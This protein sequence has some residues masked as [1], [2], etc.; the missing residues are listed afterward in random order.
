[1]GFLSDLLKPLRGPASRDDDPDYSAN[2]ERIEKVLQTLPP[3]RARLLAAFALLLGRV[4]HSDDVISEGERTR[5]LKILR[6][7]LKLAE[8]QAAAVAAI[9]LDRAACF[10]SDDHLVLRRVRELATATERLDLIRALFHLA[11]VDDISE[12]E[13]QEIRRIATGLGFGQSEYIALR[14]EFRDFLK[15]LKLELPG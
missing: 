15:I 8:D 3:E 1:M 6:E 10:D 12:Q 9:A 13:S 11:A 5:L 2:L 4:A 7:D 14:S